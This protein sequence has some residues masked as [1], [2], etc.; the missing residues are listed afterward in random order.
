MWIADSLRAAIGSVRTA[1]GRDSSPMAQAF[2]SQFAVA[3]YLESGLLKKV[4]AIPAADRTSK[5]RDWQA[6]PEVI[7]A[8][9]GEEKRLGLRAKTKQAEILRDIGGGAMVLITAGD[10][11]Q[12]LTTVPKGGIVAINVLSRWQISGLDWDTDLASPTYGEPMMWQ[13]SGGRTTQPIHPSRVIPFRGEPLAGIM[14]VSTEDAYWGDCRLMRVL[15]A[16]EI[17]DETQ[18]WF[19]ALVRKAKLLRIGIPGLSEALVSDEGKRRVADRMQ[20]IAEGEN[21]LNAVVYEASAGQDRPG[22]VI[23]DYQVSWA[24]IPAVMDAFDQRVA[25]VS[26]IPFTTLFGRS[27]AGMNATGSHDEANR[28]AQTSEAQENSLRPCLEQLD[29][30]LIASAGVPAGGVTWKFAPLSTPTDKENADTFKTTMEGLTALRAM[31]IMP[32]EAFN[33]AAQNMLIENETLPGLEQALKGYSDDE[34]YGVA[35]SDDGSDP[36]ALSEIP[37]GGKEVDPTSA[38]GGGSGSAP[39]RRAANDAKPIPLYVQRKLLNASELIAWAKSQGF[40]ATLPAD[41]MHVTV[42]YSR[43]PVDPIKMGNGWDGN[44]KGE[45]TIKPG[46]PRAV[47]K[48]GED[49]VVLLFASSD[50][51]WRHQSMV[52]AGASHDYPEYQPHVTLSYEAGDVDLATVKPFAGKLVFGPEIFEPLPLRKVTEE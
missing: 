19:S 50:L 13:V 45:I 38:G 7:T 18:V 34:R 15:R 39:A 20:T 27:P 24:G 51:V 10:H 17:S 23:T 3:K 8:I 44:D 36:S 28:W 25:A 2:G 5:W 48:L 21:I 33:R 52:E 47:E 40:S 41:D 35:P 26:G 30:F 1:W 42:L 6:P 9:E 16:V 12:P 4:I 22:E 32:E 43:T 31:E 29:P 14:G 11:A 46:G 37:N 49:A